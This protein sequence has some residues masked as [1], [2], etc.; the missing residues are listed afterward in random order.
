MAP[1]ERYKAALRALE[2]A[3]VRYVAARECFETAIAARQL[4]A[5]PELRR[6]VAEAEYALRRGFD[7]AVLAHR[8]YQRVYCG[9]EPP[10]GP[11]A[12][13]VRDLH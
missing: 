10:A 12:E 6:A 9:G 5:V 3:Q 11:E 13:L 8:A 4:A 2:Q 1:A 7:M